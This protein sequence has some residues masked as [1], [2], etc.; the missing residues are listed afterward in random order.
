M[1]NQRWKLSIIVMFSSQTGELFRIS[2]KINNLYSSNYPNLTESL[3]LDDISP[4]TG[5]KQD[6]TPAWVEK[7]AEEGKVQKRKI[8]L[9]RK[10]FL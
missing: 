4:Q 10:T 2:T 6:E 3:P 5:E 1:T 9:F 8:F 7:K